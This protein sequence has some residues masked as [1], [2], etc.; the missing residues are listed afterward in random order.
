MTNPIVFAIPVFLAAMGLELWLARR[1][2]RQ[3]YR[4]QDAM[5]SLNMGVLSQIVGVFVVAVNV[6]I[7]AAVQRGFSLFALDPASPWV[8]AG[9]LLMY[10]FLY[11]WK[12][13]AGHEIHLMWAAHVVH[14]SSE[15]YNLS[16]A[17]RQ[18]ASDFLLN[19]LYYLPMALL[20]VPVLVFVVVGLVNLLYQFWP[21]T[22]LIGKLGWFD[23]VFCSPS[24]H[25]VHHGQNDYC[26]DRNYGGILILWDRLFGTFAE[27]R[28]GEPVVYG[29][30][31]PLHSWN[32]LWGNLQ[33][34]GQIA[35]SVRATPGL[36]HKLLRIFAGPGWQP[37]GSGPEPV[38]MARAFVRFD[39]PLAP[40]ARWY[41]LLS[42]VV[43]TALLM[44]FLIASPRLPLAPSLVYGALMA[45]GM[46]GLAGVL[47]GS[48]VAAALELLR[49][50]AVFGALVAGFW[51]TPVSLLAQGAALVALL[52]SGWLL[53][54]CW[55]GARDSIP[56]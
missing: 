46:L 27:E 43:G 1:M 16:T 44:H 41:A 20:G 40:A 8:W 5:T 52:V 33:T 9:A 28:D 30:R 4:T 38:F 11:Y 37:P 47:S 10:D 32:P 14:H 35:R 50:L 25:R 39:A 23:R 31:K 54:K 48:R 56:D 29:V 7:Y 19:W 3:V 36:R 21:H 15:D 13:R 12:H 45:L 42:F 34:Y 24:N 17:L 55:L 49:A 6:G 26:L 51:F 2:G 22:Q 53:G 18:S